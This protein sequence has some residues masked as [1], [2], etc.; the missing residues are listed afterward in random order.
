[1]TNLSDFRGTMNVVD[2]G[3][4]AGGL[5]LAMARQW[6]TAQVTA[7]DLSAPAL[8]VARWNAQRHG[9]ADRIAFRLGDLLDGMSDGTADLVAANLPY[10][11]SSDIAGLSP[12][13]RKEPV[14]ALDGGADGL[15]LVR[16]LIPQAVRVLRP[17]G[18]LFLEVGRGQ[19]AS[20]KQQMVRAGFAEVDVKRDFA[21]IE[22]FLRG[23][24]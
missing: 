3:T 2:V 13:V 1:M 4:G 24:R 11:A 5:A 19:T 12:E 20:V 17:G 15:D 8:A 23:V 22:R 14:R 18:R 16:R 9:V 21:G 10:V 7:I 6:P